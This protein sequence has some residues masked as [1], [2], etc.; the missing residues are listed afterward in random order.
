MIAEALNGRPICHGFGTGF[1]LVQ[2]EA[3]ISGSDLRPRTRFSLSSIPCRSRRPF[4]ALIRAFDQ[5][6]FGEMDEGFR[7]SQVSHHSDTR[8]CRRASGAGCVLKSG[9]DRLNRQ[10]KCPR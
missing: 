8:A 4:T 6:D 10:I 5:N 3:L 7:A 2:F 1:E 9:R